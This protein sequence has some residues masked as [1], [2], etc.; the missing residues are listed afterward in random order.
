ME[1]SV[2]LTV[3]SSDAPYSVMAPLWTTDGIPIG[4]F[5][6]SLGNILFEKRA[7]GNKIEVLNGEVTAWLPFLTR[8]FHSLGTPREATVRFVCSRIWLFNLEKKLF[9]L[10]FAFSLSC[11]LLRHVALAFFSFSGE[12]S[13]VFFRFE[14]SC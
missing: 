6:A 5:G 9:S 10:Y 1:S 4:F 3:T 8:V 7:A 2:P 14:F 11:S 13:S 12:F